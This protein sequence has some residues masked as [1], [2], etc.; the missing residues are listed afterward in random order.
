MLSEYGCSEEE[1]EAHEAKLKRRKHP[2]HDL[3]KSDTFQNTLKVNLLFYFFMNRQSLN[4]FFAA[5][6]D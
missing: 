5:N 1:R 6:R 4:F 2:I 3:N